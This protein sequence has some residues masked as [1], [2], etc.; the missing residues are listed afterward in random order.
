MHLPHCRQSLLSETPWKPPD[1][2]DGK[3]SVCNA[4]DPGL[5]LDWKDDLEKGMAPHSSILAWRI[6]LD[7]V[8][9]THTHAGCLCNEILVLMTSFHLKGTT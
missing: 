5:I 3:E 7:R 2:S 6:G 8:T 1:G 4:R 9:D